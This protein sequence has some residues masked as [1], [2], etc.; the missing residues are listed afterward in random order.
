M[1][2][3]LNILASVEWSRVL[4]IG[5]PAG[6]AVV[7]WFFVNKLNARRELATRKREARLKALEIAYMRISTSMN[8]DFDEKA[9]TEIETFVAEIQ[10]YG[11]PR[12]VALMEQMVEEFKKPNFHVSYDALLSDL[13]DTIRAELTL[14]P[15]R[16]PVWWLRFSK[17]AVEQTANKTLKPTDPP[18]G[19]PAA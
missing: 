16:G 1:C 6:V 2:E 14:E 7:G 11:T 18:S 12:Q 3:L 15:L 17:V 4:S 8:R 19:G 10:L 5:I 9:A 13:R